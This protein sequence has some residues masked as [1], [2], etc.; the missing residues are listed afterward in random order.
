MVCTDP[1]AS[2]THPDPDAHRPRPHLTRPRRRL[3]RARHRLAQIQTPADPRLA[4]AETVQTPAYV[5]PDSICTR[6][7]SS[8]TNLEYDFQRTRVVIRPVQAARPWANAPA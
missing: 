5:D 6:P 8:R 2:R 3:A 4:P 1:D 7:A